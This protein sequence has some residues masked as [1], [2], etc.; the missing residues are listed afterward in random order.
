M[1]ANTRSMEMVA[2]FVEKGLFFKT[3]RVTERDRKAID[4][5]KHQLYGYRRTVHCRTASQTTARQ[6]NEAYT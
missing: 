1:K 2:A 6:V 3:K 5:F 4:Q